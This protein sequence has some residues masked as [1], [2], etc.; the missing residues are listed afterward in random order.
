MAAG[1]VVP[2]SVAEVG[3][4]RLGGVDQ[5]ALIRGRDLANP[6][7]IHLHAGAGFSETRSSPVQRHPERVAADLDTA[8]TG[9]STVNCR[10]G[11]LQQL[12]G[13]RSSR[14]DFP[15]HNGA[16]DRDQQSPVRRISG[17]RAAPSEYGKRST[18]TSRRM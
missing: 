10:P 6:P 11:A 7:L 5:W 4:S 14:R 8:Q 2:E 13:E 17:A 9:A 18:R 16:D 12:R 15:P 1:D 3:R